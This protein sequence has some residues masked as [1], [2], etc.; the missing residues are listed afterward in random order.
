MPKSLR[1]WRRRFGVGAGEHLRMVAIPRALEDFCRV[2]LRRPHRE[3]TQARM[4]RLDLIRGVPSMV[5]HVIAAVM[6]NSDI[7]EIAT[8]VGRRGNRMWRVLDVQV[9]DD[10]E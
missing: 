3:L 7:D 10:T 1:Q 8:R 2:V 5:R 6:L 9:A 4:A